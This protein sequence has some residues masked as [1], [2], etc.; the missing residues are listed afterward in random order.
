MTP[1]FSGF[2]GMGESSGEELATDFTEATD[3]TEEMFFMSFLC[4]QCSSVADRVFTA[5]WSYTAR[6]ALAHRLSAALSSVQR[7]SWF[8]FVMTQTATGWV[9]F[10]F[11]SLPGTGT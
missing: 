4:Y 9:C 6:A 11:G 2:A 8:S 3:K 10:F 5:K 7:L 1:T